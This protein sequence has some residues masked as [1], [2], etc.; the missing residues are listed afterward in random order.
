MR[1]YCTF[2]GT[3]E[4]SE[5]GCR[6]AQRLQLRLPGQEHAAAR[7]RS[8]LE[9]QAGYLVLSCLSLS[10]ELKFVLR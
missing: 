6:S 9:H 5:V 7:P 3:Q 2:C 8:R 4:G 10:F 1:M